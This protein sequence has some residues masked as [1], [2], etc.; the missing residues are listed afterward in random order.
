ML[1]NNV[2]LQ[3]TH[4]NDMVFIYIGKKAFVASELLLSTM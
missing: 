4:G 1:I 2:D 3:Y